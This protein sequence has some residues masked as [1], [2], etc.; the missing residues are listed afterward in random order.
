M[1]L[2]LKHKEA[3][4]R[5][6][7]YRKGK[8]DDDHIGRAWEVPGTWGKGPPPVWIRGEAEAHSPVAVGTEQGEH[9][10]SIRGLGEATWALREMN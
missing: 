4:V 9:F 7:T 3:H 5:K 10:P 1:C 2:L 8:R 6:T